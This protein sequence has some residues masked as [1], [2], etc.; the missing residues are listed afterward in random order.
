[1]LL[2][3]AMLGA[4]AG[5]SFG[6]L[7]ETMASMSALGRLSEPTPSGMAEF[8]RTKRTVYN[9][10]RTLDRETRDLMLR[11]GEGSRR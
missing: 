2:G 10:L 3:A 7:G 11:S 4:V 1:M 5:G 8:H 6:S 9:M